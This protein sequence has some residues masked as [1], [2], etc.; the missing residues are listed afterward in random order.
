MT[1][2]G[3]AV[4]AQTLRCSDDTRI[5]AQAICGFACAGWNIRCSG[6]LSTELPLTCGRSSSVSDNRRRDSCGTTGGVWRVPPHRRAPT[7]PDRRVACQK[8]VETVRSGPRACRCWH[9]QRKRHRQARSTYQNV[10]PHGEFRSGR[11]FRCSLD[12]SWRRLARDRA[13]YRHSS[14]NAPLIASPTGAKR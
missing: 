1:D 9:R 14:R 12:G 11:S 8:R 10:A 3:V 13:A 7:V 2:R 5:S 4:I 6:R